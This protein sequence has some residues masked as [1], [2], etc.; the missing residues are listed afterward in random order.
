MSEN[1]ENP[2][3]EP[4]PDGKKWVVRIVNAFS[5]LVR[6]DAPDAEAAKAEV[7][8]VLPHLLEGRKLNLAYDG[9]SPKESWGVIT[10]E[11][12]AEIVKEI[13][14]AQQIDAAQ[15]KPLPVAEL[16][17]PEPSNIIVLDRFR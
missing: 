7:E 15:A 6:V 9:T 8:R 14:K 12:H 11:E 16:E 5:S 2:V 4:A 3:N 1:T 17:E 13:L 10:E